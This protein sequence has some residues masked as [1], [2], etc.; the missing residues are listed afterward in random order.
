M[1]PIAD[2]LTSIQNAQRAKKESLRVSFSKLKFEIA[3][4]L[5]REGFVDKVEERG[6]YKKSILI[7][8]KYDEGRPAISGVKRISKPGQRIY[9]GYSEIKR[10][11]GGYGIAII[12]TSKGLMTDKE[13]KKQ[14]V[15]GEVI[16]E[17]W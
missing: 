1:D 10:A 11:K 6:R 4:I 7:H 2:M 8:L 14:K 9:K 13:A 15:G 16:C 3:K 17:V 5:E 12:S